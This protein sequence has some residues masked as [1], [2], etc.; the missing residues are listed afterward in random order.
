MRKA[1]RII[2][3]LIICLLLASPILI[4][5]ANGSM[6]VI[7]TRT[8]ECYHLD[9]CRTLKSRIEI[10]LE[11]AVARG[12][13]PCKVC[14][15]PKLDTSVDRSLEITEP[16]SSAE[17]AP[18]FEPE[19]PVPEQQAPVEQPVDLVEEPAY[20]T[21]LYPSEY[22]Y[23]AVVDLSNR[24]VIGGFPDGSFKPNQTVTRAQ[25]AVM[26]V[27]AN[28]LSTF[29]SQGSDFIDVPKSNWAYPF[30]ST[31]AEAGYLGGYP[32]GSFKPDKEV[33]YNEALTMIVASLGYKMA[34][35][36]GSYP[37]CFTNKAKE[38]GVLNTCDKI[39]T[40]I[41]TRAEVSCFLSDSFSSPRN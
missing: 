33:S 30:I 22:Y 39:G 34:D 37:D 3:I 26:L 31:A 15:P 18:W 32:D 14:N 8:G 4:Y 10:T 38:I 9:G 28:N 21:D 13:R 35:L 25:L 16:E 12:Y 23:K 27:N 24:G 5:A 17:P 29:A 7:I 6:T 40:G 41:V 11:E 1:N 36:Q 19:P 2:S 20:F